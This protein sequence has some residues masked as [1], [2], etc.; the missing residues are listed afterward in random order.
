MAVAFDVSRQTFRAR[1]FPDYKAQRAKSPEEFKGQ[2]GLIQEILTAA[3]V[4]VLFKDDYEADD[5]LATLSTQATA[6]G[7]RTSICT[8]DRDSIQ[9]VNELVTV[10]YPRKGT[11]DLDRLT[12]ERVEEKYGLTPA[13][14][15]DMAALVGEKSDNIPG[16][17]KVGE[18]TAIKWLTTYDGFE[19]LLANADNIKGVAGKNF[20]A[21]VDQ[22]RL[23]RELNAL[24]RDVDLP[25]KPADCALAPVD[26]EALTQQLSALEFRPQMQEN[27]LT[28]VGHDT[29]TAAPTPR[30]ELTITTVDATRFG[31]WCANHPDSVFGIHVEHQPQP[32]MAVATTDGHCAYLPLTDLDNT[33]TSTLGECL[34]TIQWV[35]HEAKQLTR[36][37]HKY[38]IH[39]NAPTSDVE[40]M[41]YL[42]EPDRRSRTISDLAMR[43]LNRELMP[44]D[45][46]PEGQLDLG[47]ATVDTAEPHCDRALAIAELHR[48]LQHQVTERAQANLLDTMELPLQ[49]VL[50]TMENTGIACSRSHL[51][52]L[53][54]EFAAVAE[55]LRA[56][57]CAQ[58]GRE[59]NL[60]SPKQLQEVLFT[61]L[62]M[63]KTRKIKT[64]YSTNADALAD[65]FEKTHHPFLEHLLAH[66]EVT[67]QLTTVNGLLDAIA[68]DGRIHTRFQQTAA[69]TGR[70]SSTDPNLQNIPVRTAEG[71][72]IREAFVPG[73]GFDGLLSADYSQIEMRI[74]AHLC[75]DESLLDAFRSGEDLHAFVGSQVF[76]VAPSDVDDSMRSKVKAMSYGLAYGLSAFGLAKQLRIGDAEAKELMKQYFDRFGGVK[77]YLD[78]VVGQARKDGYTETIMGRRRYLPD[79]N[80]SNRQRRDMAERA[81]LNAPIQG[82]AA[83]I[84]KV[85]MLAIDQ[86]LT[87]RGLTSRL[88]LQ[89]HD[90]VIVEVTDAERDEVTELVVVAMGSAAELRVPL[91]VNTGWGANWHEAAH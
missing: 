51:I 62:D 10:L 69:A 66:R 41:A 31:R 74:M 44:L 12:P 28:A 24:L 45:H 52:G 89:V 20:A 40:L 18:K 65:L 55:Q 21:M 32:A 39:P 86:E 56:D 67:K 76:G 72:R 82:S 7:F 91:A 48:E 13:M 61:D 84:M 83:D 58:V 78:D 50:L 30:V 37:L 75:Q 64:G 85:A 23:N 33:A 2:V 81:A 17:A 5:I 77:E 54:T 1:K 26:V 4:T 46:V 53:Q 90:E 57:A 14:Y 3:G 73:D 11:A 25:K 34:S 59:V 6:E 88:L 16:V 42:V 49:Q 80:S 79:L 87:A 70:L 63:P 43:L 9:L 60:A 19:N 35:C 8:G 47:Q 22:V 36:A 29:P 71:R 38:G 27:L 68:A 15:P